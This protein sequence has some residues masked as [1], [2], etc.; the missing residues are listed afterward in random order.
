MPAIDEHI[1]V[2]GSEK[3]DHAHRAACRRLDLIELFIDRREK[4]KS[5]LMLGQAAPDYRFIQP[6]DVLRE[7]LESLGWMQV[8]EQSE[9]SAMHIEIHQCHRLPLPGL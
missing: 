8:Q 1:P 5:R 7:V 3:T 4:V 2:H 9:I 6:R